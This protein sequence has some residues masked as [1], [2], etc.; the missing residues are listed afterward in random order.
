MYMD[1]L[2]KTIHA[3][4]KGDSAYTVE[5]GSSYAHNL[6]KLEG[7]L[8]TI[9]SVIAKANNKLN[10]LRVDTAEAQKIINTPF[11]YE[12]ELNTKSARLDTL[13][14]ELNKAAMEAKLNNPNKERTAYFDRA[15]LKKEAI[16]SKKTDKKQEKNKETSI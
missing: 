12:A 3:T 9:D 16:K 11:S 5:F 6:K 4:L 7:A 14:D 10:Q 15:K 13:T 8:Y 1:S 2:T